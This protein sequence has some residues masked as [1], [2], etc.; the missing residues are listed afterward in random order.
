VGDVNG[1]KLSNDIFGHKKGDEFLV[2]IAQIIRENTR[3]EDIVFRVG[4]D[5]FYLFMKNT[6]EDTARTIM[7]RISSSI[8][9]EDFHGVRGGIALGLSVMNSKEMS[10]DEIMTDAE[11]KMYREKTLT[12]SKDNTRQLKSLID[13]I[14]KSEEEREH[15]ENTVKIA[16]DIGKALSLTEDMLNKL[17]DAAFVHDI[18]RITQI[19]SEKE[20]RNGLSTRK[21]HAVIGYRIL[22]SFDSTMDIARIVLSHHEKWDGS[23]YP[24]GLVGEE[25]PLL[26]RIITVAERYDRLTSRFSLTPLT[27]EDAF[28]VMKMESGTILD[29]TLVAL[30]IE[31]KENRP[32]T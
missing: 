5:E 26:S 17:K 4:G 27:K 13:I 31:G 14:M 21:D 8:S 22:N 11:Q 32:V 24:K 7:D 29:G 6:N 3:E 12:K 23:G 1:L 18:G 16:E 2:K 28:S 30:L 15:A 19:M 25:I 10:L 9:E 20:N